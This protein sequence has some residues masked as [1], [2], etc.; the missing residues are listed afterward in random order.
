MIIK[1]TMKKERRRCKVY[2]RRRTAWYNY[3]SMREST[4]HMRKVFEERDREITRQCLPLPIFWLD[5]P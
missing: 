3:H 5:R 4:A 2:Q 1:H